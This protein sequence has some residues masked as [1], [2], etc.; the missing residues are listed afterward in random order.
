[1]SRKTVS[2]LFS[3][4]TCLYCNGILRAANNV[5]PNSQVLLFAVSK[6]YEALKVAGGEDFFAEWAISE[7]M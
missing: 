3:V 2:Q 5:Q 6:F 1:L 4:C 7:L